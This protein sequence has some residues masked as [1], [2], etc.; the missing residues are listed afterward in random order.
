MPVFVQENN[1]NELRNSDSNTCL[2]K[3]KQ[4]IYIALYL[5]IHPFSVKSVCHINAVSCIPHS[6]LYL[7]IIAPI[8]LAISNNMFKLVN[9]G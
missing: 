6:T 9:Q 7:G 1:K 5:V 2:L 4:C 3:I 8:F